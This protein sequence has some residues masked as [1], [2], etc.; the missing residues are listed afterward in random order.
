[1]TYNWDACDMRKFLLANGSLSTM[2]LQNRLIQLRKRIASKAARRG[3]RKRAMGESR[4][5][6][7]GQGAKVLGRYS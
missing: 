1:M 6:V 5:N 3:K 2:G 4:S 7:Q